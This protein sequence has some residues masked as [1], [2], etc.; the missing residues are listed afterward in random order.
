MTACSSDFEFNEEVAAVFDDMLS[1]SIPF[2][3]EQQSL[4]EEIARQ[5]YV[6]G[7]TVVDLGSSTGTILI[8]LANT[9]GS[10]CMLTGYDSSRPMIKRASRKISEANPG[11]CI[12]IRYGDLN[13]KPDDLE[14]RHASIVTLCW[15]L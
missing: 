10:D 7:S 6:P 4:I 11:E 1:R 3:H 13:D 15:T 2:Y 8:R 5:F 9:L 14:I 12:T